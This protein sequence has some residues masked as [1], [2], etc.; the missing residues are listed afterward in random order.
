[1]NLPDKNRPLRPVRNPF[2][3][4]LLLLDL[5]WVGVFLAWN[6]G[7][8][9][10]ILLKAGW[11]PPD[12]SYLQLLYR[13]GGDPE[14]G[15]VLLRLASDHGDLETA[16]RL[17]REAAPLLEG[18]P[19]SEATALLESCFFRQPGAEELWQTVA[20]RFSRKAPSLETARLLERIGLLAEAARLYERLF[21]S[22][23]EPRRVEIFSKIVRLD[24]AMGDPIRALE[25]AERLFQEI[26]DPPPELY[27]KLIETA[28]L[29]GKPKRAAC[30]SRGLVFRE[31]PKC[32]SQE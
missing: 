11:N 27:R 23:G 24:L 7:Q 16:C 21:T 19:L 6:V 32:V 4:G 17:V 5:L 26:E 1:M 30:Y 3:F 2:P 29:A 8:P 22:S 31:R 28:L 18:L 20:L 13:H 10:Q 14:V 9:R 25:R 12:R 15:S